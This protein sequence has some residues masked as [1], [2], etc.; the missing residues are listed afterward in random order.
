[1]R[2]DPVTTV[3]CE[4][5]N[6]SYEFTA[7]DLAPLDS[8][9]TLSHMGEGGRGRQPETGEVRPPKALTHRSRPRSVPL[10]RSAGEGYKMR[11][12]SKS[13]T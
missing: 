7:D 8:V 13:F 2:Q 9:K 4:F 11:R 1:M 5:C 6:T 10:S 12:C 3:T